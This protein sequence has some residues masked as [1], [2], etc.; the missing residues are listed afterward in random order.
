MIRLGQRLMWPM[1]GSKVPRPCRV[2]WMH[3]KRRFAVLEWDLSFR[4]QWG[5]LIHRPVREAVQIRRRRRR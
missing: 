3:P 2:V 5:V 1:W 4:D